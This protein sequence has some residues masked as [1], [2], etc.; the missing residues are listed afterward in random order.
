MLKNTILFLTTTL[1]L[2]C[3][4]EV[5]GQESSSQSCDCYERLRE[6][7]TYYTSQGSHKKSLEV[8]RQAL[9]FAKITKPY[10][11]YYLATLM[12][13]N[14]EC[15]MA[16]EYLSMA[17]VKGYDLTYIPY[18]RNLP[19]C[20]ATTGEAW[21]QFLEKV[22]ISNKNTALNLDFEYLKALYDIRG[23]DQTIRRLIKVPQETYALLDS[24]NFDRLKKLIDE[25]GYPDYQK[26]GFE[27]P[28]AAYLVL[29]HATRYDEKMYKEV[30][31]ILK[32]ANEEG[33]IRGYQI[34]QMIDERTSNILKAEQILGTWNN[35]GAKEFKP[36]A[37]PQSVDSLRFEYNLLR[38]KEQAKLEN[39][40]LPQGYLPIPY[41][42]DYFCGYEFDQ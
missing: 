14:G 38:L 28:Q 33:N 31:S 9:N 2:F 15:I 27:D 34:A 5:K 39:R 25:K 29:V 26:H 22:K 8:Y 10:D 19:T 1:F 40:Q 12:A 17:I 6:L 36:I 24:I 13:A 42:E 4:L 41:P 18:D 3:F 21:K 23:S 11:Y 20:L 30:M 16:K 7:S 37:Q 35:Y 32:T